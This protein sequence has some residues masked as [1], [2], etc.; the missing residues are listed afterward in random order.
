M[1]VIRRQSGSDYVAIWKLSGRS[2][3]VIEPLCGNYRASVR[4]LSGLCVELLRS[5]YESYQAFVWKL[6]GHSLEVVGPLSESYQ[7]CLWNFPGLCVEVLRPLCGSYQVAVLNLSGHSCRP[8]KMHCHSKVLVC[9]QQETMAVYSLNCSDTCIFTL[10]PWS[11]DT[12][13]LLR[14]FVVMSLGY[15]LCTDWL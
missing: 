12:F 15:H 1:D 5:L 3:D 11:S 8:S 14:K 7:T 2:Q 13:V 6:S 9:L 10:L 4:M